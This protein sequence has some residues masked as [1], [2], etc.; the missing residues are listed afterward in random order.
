MCP[1]S[2]LVC[3]CPRQSL[4]DFIFTV[5]C[6]AGA[7]SDDI[8]LPVVRVISPLGALGGGVPAIPA[9][10]RDYFPEECYLHCD[11]CEKVTLIT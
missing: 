3:V 7:L 1:V 2:A 11:V 4:S 6:P 5:T 9:V 10:V 8:K